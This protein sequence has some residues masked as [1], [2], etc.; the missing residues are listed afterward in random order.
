MMRPMLSV[1]VVL[2]RDEFSCHLVQVIA[3]APLLQTC[4]GVSIASFLGGVHWGMAMAEYGGERI[5][6]PWQL[7]ATYSTRMSINSK[8]FMHVIPVTGRELSAKAA[9]E[10][11]FWSI[12]PSLI[13]FPAVTLPPLGS[14]LVIAGTLGAV[15]DPPPLT[16]HNS[17]ATLAGLA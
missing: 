2:L 15:S 16:F 10:R 4:Y 5:P 7:V 13:A 12:T 6:I 14:S 11:Y 3:N 8:C 9:I 17:V 1:T